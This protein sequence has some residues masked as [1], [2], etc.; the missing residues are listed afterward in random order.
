MPTTTSAEQ[1]L[2]NDSEFLD[3][4]GQFSDAGQERA[5]Q[6]D[7]LRR[8]YR[9]AFDALDGGLATDGDAPGPVSPGGDADPTEESHVLPANLSAPERRGISF[10]TVALV[11]VTCLTAG[12]ATAAYLFRDQLTHVT[13]RP[14]ASR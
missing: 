3:E 13:A 7:E 9:D 1:S 2:I 10:I 12:A 8:P 14:S 6:P 4:L 11:L 5:V